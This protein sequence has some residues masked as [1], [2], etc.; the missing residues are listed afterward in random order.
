MP[1]K[2]NCNLS[3]LDALVVE[4][5]NFF[6]K[7]YLWHS[8]FLDS[9]L[10]SLPE[11]FETTD[12]SVKLDEF[13]RNG[14]SKLAISFFSRF[15]KLKCLNIS[16]DG[17]VEF[18]PL[19]T[20]LRNNPIERIEI[21]FKNVFYQFETLFH[22][23]SQHKFQSFRM[24]G[25][26]E[27]DNFGTDSTTKLFAAKFWEEL[28][29]LE[30]DS[31]SLHFILLI[32]EKANLPKLRT[33]NLNLGR[34]HEKI[35][36]SATFPQVRNLVIKIEAPE[37]NSPH[38]E[39]LSGLI[40]MFPEISSLKIGDPHRYVDLLGISCLKNLRSLKIACASLMNSDDFIMELSQLPSLAHF[41]F[42]DFN[43]MYS[44]QVTRGKHLNFP[45]LAFVLLKTKN[46]KINQSFVTE[47][48]IL[49]KSSAKFA[50]LRRI[51]AFVLR[52]LNLE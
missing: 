8:L 45:M 11:N 5:I 22:A 26:F 1:L 49:K 12:L 48:S 9:S 37:Y 28:E 35:A 31:F 14:A 36:I 42:R 43:G 13:Q 2:L 25:N 24:G 41:D 21:K 32:M 18:E 47:A 23:L 6:R 33:V 40:A 50:L 16:L 10:D 3:H 19:K 46:P 4:N 30:F 39:Y 38:M 15:S 7:F 34:K 20:L 27:V 29:I 17:Y 52:R 44:L 51:S